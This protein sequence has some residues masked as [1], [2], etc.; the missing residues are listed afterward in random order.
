MAG[1]R[2]SKSS[3]IP[4]TCGMLNSNIRSKS[5]EPAARSAYVLKLQCNVQQ[6]IG[7][8][9]PGDCDVAHLVVGGVNLHR[10][11]QDSVHARIAPRLMFWA[12][13]WRSHQ[14]QKRLVA[15]V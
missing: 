11:I 4:N 7:T 8:Q 5:I 10:R 6:P 3:V 13:L 2:L 12:L 14:Q 15:E 9:V 1:I